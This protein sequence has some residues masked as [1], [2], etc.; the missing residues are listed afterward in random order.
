MKE[1]FGHEKSNIGLIVS[2]SG[3]VLGFFPL[4]HSSTPGRSRCFPACLHTCWQLSCQYLRPALSTP[5]RQVFSE[6]QLVLVAI[7]GHWKRLCLQEDYIQPVLFLPS[8][9]LLSATSISWQYT[10][11]S[12]SWFVLGSSDGQMKLHEAL[13]LFIQLVH[14]SAKLLEASFALVG[15]LLDVKILV[16]MN[17]KSVAFC[18]QPVNVNNKRSV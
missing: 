6:P 2:W 12:W 8:A 4:S 15:H 1:S 3:W 18:T 9:I 13:K 17:L 14:P 5:L 16:G 7:V 10:L 11:S